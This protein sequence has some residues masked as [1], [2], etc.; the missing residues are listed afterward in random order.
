VKAVK[1]GGLAGLA[2]ESPQGVLD[3]FANAGGLEC[4][5]VQTFAGHFL[6]SLTLGDA[7]RIGFSEAG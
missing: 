2:V 6:F 7:I 1:A 4:Q 3:V 5:L